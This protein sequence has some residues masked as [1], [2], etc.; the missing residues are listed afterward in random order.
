MITRLS[1]KQWIVWCLWTNGATRKQ[2]AESLDVS[3]SSANTH[4]KRISRKLDTT[5]PVQAATK[6]VTWSGA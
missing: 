2:V 3:L 4:I 5:G 6:Q 1:R